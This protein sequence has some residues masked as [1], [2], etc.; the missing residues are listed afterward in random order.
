MTHALLDGMHRH[1]LHASNPDMLAFHE[2]FA[3]IVALLQHFS[4]PEVVRGQ[5]AKMG[6]KLENQGMLGQLAQQFGEAMGM[7]GSL[8]SYL[9]NEENGVWK[10]KSPD[11]KLYATVDEPHDRGAILVAAMFTAFLT[12]YR[13][14]TRDL[15]RIATNGS[16]IHAPG[17]L[18]PDLVN[19]LSDEAAKAANHLLVMAVR[20]LDYVP[21]VDLTFGEYLRALITSDYDLI[22]GDHRLYRVAILDA[23]RQWGIYPADVQNL[24]VESLLWGP[25]EN[26]SLKLE[27]DLFRDILAIG[28]G[29][30]KLDR[31]DLYQHQ[32]EVRIK[33]HIWMRDQ[34]ATNADL[35]AEW[36]LDMSPSAPQTI[37]RDNPKDSK[38]PRLP[39]FDVH[40]V[41]RCRRIG[42]DEQERVDILIEVVQKRK[43]Y[44]D[45]SVQEKADGG[46]IPSGEPDFYFR[47]G[48]TII[49]D[50]RAGR[51]RYVIRKSMNPKKTKGL[52]SRLE[53]T[54]KF[55][56]GGGGAL[57]LRSNYFRGGEGTNPFVYLH[58]T[59]E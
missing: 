59:E 38:Q 37:E 20:A 9:G 36:G 50:P 45:E 40:S 29:T 18:H 41:R 34:F 21:P 35:A 5:I 46:S 7:H 11:P 49:I 57:G 1:L 22:P 14:R 4:H 33:L 2:A 42:P 25:P 12:I 19:R 52:H 13:N 3:D 39:K 27:M 30:L 16:G 8:R 58:S 56:T 48:A 26:A 47:G 17:A 53:K 28:N 23:F 15:M 6:G 10:P 43:C 55:A 31:A 51:I 44:I 54:R 24:S 32:R